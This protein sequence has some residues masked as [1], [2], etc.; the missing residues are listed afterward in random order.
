MPNQESS[1]RLKFLLITHTF[2][3]GPAQELRDYFIKNKI[4]FSF[5][6]HPFSYNKNQERSQITF[7]DRGEEGQCFKGVKIKGP[8]ICYFIRDFLSSIYFVVK[9]R[10]KYDVCI[11]ADN[12]NAFSAWFLKKLGYIKKLVYWTVD[13]APKRFG[14]NIMDKIYHKVDRFC[15]YYSD[16]I[17]SSSKRM[18]AARAANGVDVKR[19]A[20][21]IIV[22]D[23]CHFDDIKRLS[24]SEMYRFRLVFMGHLVEGKGVELIISA[25]PELIRRYP[26]VSLVIIGTGPEEKRLMNLAKGLSLGKNV[27]FVGFVKRHEDLEAMIAFCGIALAPYLP[28]PNNLTFFSDVGKVRIYMACGLP[29]LITD[30]PE[31]AK[32]IRDMGAGAI[33]E[34]NKEDFVRQ[35][36]FLLD[37]KE[38]YISCRH[39][40]IELAERS[41]WK[42]VF[43]NAFSETLHD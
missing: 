36:C 26:D 3:T 33:F 13:Y 27:E 4:S 23:G 16:L 42:N 18:A 39:N 25:M 17:W 40:A 35:V 28:D 12:L 2:A 31:I 8:E 10:R 6:E 7:F 37:D 38:K 41:D 32:D 11:A 24:D 19:C 29:V 30:V 9:A 20:K 14:N 5:I 34:Y 15:C 1:P 21:E 22:H 43:K